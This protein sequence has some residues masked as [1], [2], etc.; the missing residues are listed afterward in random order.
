MALRSCLPS[1]QPNPDPSKKFVWRPVE[2]LDARG[3]CAQVVATSCSPTSTPHTQPPAI[4]HL[5]GR[6][7]QKRGEPRTGLDVFWC[8]SANYD[9][10]IPKKGDCGTGS[11]GRWGMAGGWGWVVESPT[12]FWALIDGGVGQSKRAQQCRFGGQHGQSACI[13]RSN[14]LFCTPD[15]LRAF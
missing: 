4:P 14:H 5:P 15:S 9:D 8:D 7:P 12:R 10:L 1:P 6:D 3:W 11:S 2:L 13:S